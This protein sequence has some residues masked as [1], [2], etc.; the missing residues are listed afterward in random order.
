MLL[1]Q[2]L[3][4]KICCVNDVAEARLAISYGAA[5]IG[6]VSQMPVGPGVISDRMIAEIA[7]ELP[8]DI[9]TFLLT[10][11]TDPDQIARQAAAAG[12]NTVQICDRL[13]PGAHQH[14]RRLARDLSLVQV[15]HVLDEASYHEALHVAPH[16][17]SLLLDSG[18]PYGA[19]R[20]LGGTG[21]THD[22]EISRRIVRDVEIP[23]LLAGG[24]NADNVG[25]AIRKVRPYG[26]DVCTGVRTS[27]RLDRTKLVA[28]FEAVW[29]A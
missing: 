15:V 25:E 29:N 5:A 28:F 11:L 20:E 6:L 27:R 4:I 18:N 9:G 19:E 24:L 14:L 13:A 16:V 26:V 1:G 22:W 10:S 8:P 2:S 23:V 17:D 12:V 7:S 21:R 3:A